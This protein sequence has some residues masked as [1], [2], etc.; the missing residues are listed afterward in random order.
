M[1]DFTPHDLPKRV[2]PKADI[3]DFVAPEIIKSKSYSEKDFSLI[4]KI[5][6]ELVNKGVISNDDGLNE[7]NA[8][9]LNEILSFMSEANEGAQS[10]QDYNPEYYNE[11]L[12]TELEQQ[13]LI[14]RED[15]ENPALDGVDDFGEQVYDDMRSVASYSDAEAEIDT[16]ADVNTKSDVD[17]DDNTDSVDE[18]FSDT[19][20][21]PHVSTESDWRGRTL[22]NLSDG[23][24]TIGRI[25]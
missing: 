4:K 7:N 10:E 14:N 3:S 19:N 6:G 17:T 18:N 20:Y 1:G 23:S 5:Q 21:I 24:G 11:E 16:E 9:S 8:Q 2:L 12:I 25:I 13:G 15:F 22:I